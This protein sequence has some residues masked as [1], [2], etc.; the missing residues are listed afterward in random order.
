MTNAWID[1]P[2][3]PE[4]Q[5]WCVACVMFAKAR[6]NTEYGHQI[7]S[8]A[9]DGIDEDFVIKPA[10]PPRLEVAV[11]RGLCAQVQQL[12]I[13]DLCWTHVAG[14]Q[15]QAVSALDPAYQ[16]QPVQIPPGLLRGR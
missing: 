9:A 8:L 4:G 6:I 14:V 11:V 16:K 15:V 2:R 7:T 5:Q 13:L 3:P 1:L 10:R 12:G